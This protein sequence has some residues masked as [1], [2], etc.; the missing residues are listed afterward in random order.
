MDDCSCCTNSDNCPLGRESCFD[1]VAAKVDSFCSKIQNDANCQFASNL[2]CKNYLQP[3]TESET[4][5]GPAPTLA[6]E[7][8]EN[9]TSKGLYALSAL[10]LVPLIIA[11]VFVRKRN[12][13]STPGYSNLDDSHHYPALPP[14]SLSNASPLSQQQLPNN[15]DSFQPQIGDSRELASVAAIP[16]QSPSIESFKLSNKDQCRTHI[17]EVRE[18]PVADAL[19]VE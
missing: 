3:D 19:L 4:S 8:R 10:V 15:D 12:C 1:A 6:P 9:G 11:S 14:T 17:G 16:V 5:K 13:K 18:L 2:I 7:H